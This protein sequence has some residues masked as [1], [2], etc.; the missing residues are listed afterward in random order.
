M[1]LAV[2]CMIDRLLNVKQIRS[3]ASKKAWRTRKRMAVA[4][5]GK[6][7]ALNLDEIPPL[8]LDQKSLWPAYMKRALPCPEFGS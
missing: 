6:P 3:A 2:L 1:L 4:R 8:D 7:P 5:S